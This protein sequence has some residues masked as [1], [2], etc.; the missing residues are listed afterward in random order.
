MDKKEIVIPMPNGDELVAEWDDGMPYTI[1]VGLRNSG[2]WIQDLALI[3]PVGTVDFKP[4]NK[5]SLYVY[6]NEYQEDYTHCFE[7]NR[8]PDE[9]L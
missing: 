4:E 2:V 9:Y 8:I 7:V 3:E 5:Y 1:A 6:S